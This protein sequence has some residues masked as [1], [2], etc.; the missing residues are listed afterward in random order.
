MNKISKSDQDPQQ[1]HKDKASIEQILRRKSRHFEIGAPVTVNRTRYKI[2]SYAG[3][4]VIL[5]D[6]DGAAWVVHNPYFMQWRQ[7]EHLQG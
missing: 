2:H 1:I 7:N 5:L 4:S 6:Q 3:N